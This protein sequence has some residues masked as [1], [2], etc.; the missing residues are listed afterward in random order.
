[1]PDATTFDHGPS[2]ATTPRT[3]SP[4][5]S[6]QM[7]P[8]ATYLITR[9]DIDSITELIK[10]NLNERHRH[11]RRRWT[12]TGRSR[13]PTSQ[14]TR[15]PSITKT[16]LVPF[17]SPPSSSTVSVVKIVRSSVVTVKPPGD[18]EA[19]KSGKISRAGSKKSQEST[20]EVIWQGAGGS[21]QSESPLTEEEGARSPHASSS[22]PMTSDKG[23]A[24]DPKNATASIN[25][26]SFRSMHKDLQI[27]TS[28]ESEPDEPTPPGS[29]PFKPSKAATSILSR[30]SEEAFDKT[31]S[32]SGPQNES[33][34][35]RKPRPRFRTLEEPVSFPPLL[36]RKTTFDWYSPLPEID[37]PQQLEPSRS[38]Y[39]LGLDITHGPSAMNS[40]TPTPKASR[41]PSLSLG[42]K[43]RVPTIELHSNYV[44]QQKKTEWKPEWPPSGSV[45]IGKDKDSDRKGSIRIHPKAIART[46]E[47]L[48]TGNSI[49]A[50]SGKRRSS[51]KALQHVRTVDNAHKGEGIDSGRWRR[52]SKYPAPAPRTP[53]P[54]EE[55]AEEC[56][57]ATP[58]P[59]QNPPDQMPTAASHRMSIVIGKAPPLPKVDHV[60]IYGQFTGDVKNGLKDHCLEDCNPHVCDDC[61]ADPRQPSVDWIG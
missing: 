59:Q 44:P 24:F 45:G 47:Y 53:S 29:R 41:K 55:E 30:L 46:G 13:R 50:S 7:R 49:G 1:M 61:E 51:V 10:A 21:P 20:H 34:P 33:I 9:Q 42:H 11:D 12:R 18:P 6:Y 14:G 26:W 37:A 4:H 43:S 31:Q 57:L 28:S 52:P 22:D 54:S 2:G 23:D 58:L 48:T 5:D 60:G 32:Q 36:A 40:R 35:S 8:S 38:L 3:L 27:F 19:A 16:G 17:D 56:L 25:E 39:E 15:S